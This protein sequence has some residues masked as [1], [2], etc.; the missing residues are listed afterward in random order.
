[1]REDTRRPYQIDGPAA[2]DLVGDA[3][4]AALRVAG[5]RVDHA[6]GILEAG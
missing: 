1:M 2:T 3:D 6:D 5:L 4:I